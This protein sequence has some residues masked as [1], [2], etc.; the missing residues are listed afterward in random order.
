MATL[1]RG[2][3]D[4]IAG[5]LKLLVVMGQNG[6]MKNQLV[7]F[8][9]QSL[10]NKWKTIGSMEAI[11][12]SKATKEDIKSEKAEPEKSLREK[13]L[14]FTKQ[15]ILEKGAENY[16]C[17]KW[18]TGVPGIGTCVEPAGSWER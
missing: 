3:F 8:S 10:L 12:A 13:I 4:E 1:L 17:A 7:N 11:A 18:S 6:F 15:L 5:T 9:S 14:A 2:V 16:G